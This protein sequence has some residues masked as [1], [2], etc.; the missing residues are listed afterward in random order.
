MHPFGIGLSVFPVEIRVQREMSA[1][2]RTVRTHDR[3]DGTVARG[4]RPGKA[5]GAQLNDLC[6]RKT[7]FSR[8]IA[9]P[10]IR[11]R[12]GVEIAAW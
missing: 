7:R 10:T 9:D 5:P 6:S 8:P 11:F 3:P 12:Q 2:Q 1:R 4:A